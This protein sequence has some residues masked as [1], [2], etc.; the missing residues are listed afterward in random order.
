MDPPQSALDAFASGGQ[1]GLWIWIGVSLAGVIV[2]GG[3]YMFK[4]Y[5]SKNNELEKQVQSLWSERSEALRERCLK[6]EEETEKLRKELIESRKNE[7]ERLLEVQRLR[8]ELDHA[9][10]RVRELEARA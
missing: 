3:V 2:A 5:T 8:D 4:I 6:C 9:R 10:E 7:V 1:L